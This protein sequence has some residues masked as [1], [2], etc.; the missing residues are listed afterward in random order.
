MGEGEGK[1]GTVPSGQVRMRTDRASEKE[2]G[3]QEKNV[4]YI[5]C[6]GPMSHCVHYGTRAKER[7]AASVGMRQSY[8]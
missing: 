1:E 2:E 7:S 8:S 4:F 3:A 6:V 5:S